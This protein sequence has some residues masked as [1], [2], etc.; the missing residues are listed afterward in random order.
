[1]KQTLTFKVNQNCEM[2]SLSIFYKSKPYLLDLHM[3]QKVVALISHVGLCGKNQE[4]AFDS[5]C[6][7][8]LLVLSKM[9]IT[10]A[11]GT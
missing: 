3:P 2:V 6:I 8:D 11:H 7:L 4:L 9:T 10:D 1:M 5:H